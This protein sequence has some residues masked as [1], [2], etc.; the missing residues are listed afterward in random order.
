MFVTT[1]KLSN[2]YVTMA[3]SVN[4]VKIMKS[5]K[6]ILLMQKFGKM[7][8]FCQ[9]L[10]YISIVLYGNSYQFLQNLLKFTENLLQ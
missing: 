6:K 7:Y 5:Q 4:A 9:F 2:Y 8:Q 3:K 10:R 1:V